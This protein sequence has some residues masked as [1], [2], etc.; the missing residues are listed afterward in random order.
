MVS[1][2]IVR[3][4]AVELFNAGVLKFGKFYSPSGCEVNAWFDLLLV[5]GYPSLMD[6][7]CEHASKFCVEA[8]LNYS[9]VCGVTYGGLPFGVLL[10]SK[11][12]KPLIMWNKEPSRH[13]TDQR[14]HGRILKNEYC[15]LVEEVVA[16]GR[17][18]LGVIKDIENTGMKV[19]DIYSIINLEQGGDENLEKLGYKLH[20]LMTMSQFLQILF[21]EK[22]IA[23]N[24]YDSSMKGFSEF[25]CS[26]NG[27]VITNTYLSRRKSIQ[28]EK[29]ID[30]C[31]SQISKKLLKL[32]SA[33]KSNLCVEF[34]SPS[35]EITSQVAELIGPYICM[36]SICW[37]V[38]EKAEELQLIR[39]VE[40]SRKHNFLLIDDSK[41]SEDGDVLFEQC[42]RRFKFVD[43]LTIYPISGKNTLLLIK[44]LIKDRFPEKGVFVVAFPSIVDALAG[45][46][47]E[48]SS[49]DITL[50]LF[51]EVTGFVSS[52]NSTIPLN[53]IHMASD[54]KNS[55][56]VAQSSNN[57]FYSSEIIVQDISADIIK[58]RYNSL[59]NIAE[60]V[61]NEQL[62]LWNAYFKRFSNT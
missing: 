21:D 22:L 18:I 42:R 55:G 3:E 17:S 15:I 24:Q 35:V 59:E 47:F 8:N 1:E 23:E 46:N 53:Y 49:I 41:L 54:L 51:E 30:S 36:L 16:S 57:S 43:L 12:H 52:K 60:L 44:S 40:I 25:K 10:A 5:Y 6:K 58:L 20:S 7:I 34:I 31:K 11:V 61:K 50:K 33:K 39:L 56:N 13:S 48:K 4:L 27:D 19:K 32:M 26:P 37:H 14:I 62:L 45:S 38:F 28:Y 29:R 9:A 2:L